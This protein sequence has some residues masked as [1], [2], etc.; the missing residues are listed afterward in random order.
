MKFV[1]IFLPT[2]EVNSFAP[3]P[4]NHFRIFDSCFDA[5]LKEEYNPKFLFTLIICFFVFVNSTTIINIFP[6]ELIGIVVNVGEYERIE[7]TQMG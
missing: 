7:P 1:I 4:D 5:I 6:I 2:T 3:P